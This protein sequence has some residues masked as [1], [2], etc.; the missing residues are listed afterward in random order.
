MIYLSYELL[1]AILIYLPTRKKWLLRRTCKAFNDV[2]LQ[3]LFS[4]LR[5]L[6]R[7]CKTLP[8]NVTF[9][10]HEMDHFYNFV[11]Q[12]GL[13][14]G[15]PRVTESHRYEWGDQY[16]YPHEPNDRLPFTLTQAS[17]MHNPLYASVCGLMML[18]LFD[19]HR[20]E[21]VV[22][23]CGTWAVYC[24]H[25]KPRRSVVR[26]CPGNFRGCGGM[27]SL[28]RNMPRRGYWYTAR[29]FR[30]VRMWEY[31][32]YLEEAFGVYDAIEDIERRCENFDAVR[33]LEYQEAG[34]FGV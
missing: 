10:P 33:R 6:Q 8:G 14:E 4:R 15:L 32:S 29:I 24:G 22:A 19:M 1:D 13:Y 27:V 12:A 2:L 17:R 25:C 23:V 26:S 21:G 9:L 28:N 7:A 5:K 34:F 31:Q 20:E 18:H 16:Q 11:L 30:A 3:Q